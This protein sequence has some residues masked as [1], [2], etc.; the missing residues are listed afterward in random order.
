MACITSRAWKASSALA[1]SARKAGKNQVAIQKLQAAIDVL[2]RSGAKSLVSFL[3]PSMPGWKAGEPKTVTGN[4][5]AGAQAFQWTQVS[6]TYTRDEDGLRV[7][8]QFTN[9]PQLIQGQRQMAAMF[10][11]EQY[12]KM[13]NNDPNKEIRVFKKVG[14]TGWTILEKGRKANGVALSED[15]MVTL[16]VS[17]DKEE[18]F[19]KFWKGV[20]FDG[21]LASGSGK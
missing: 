9:S 4:W 14:W 5:G 6:R 11:N 10:A 12:V 8:V 20:D 7:N 18:V 21:I 17:Q 15:V 1:R 2:Q 16:D 3:P 13:M 19:A